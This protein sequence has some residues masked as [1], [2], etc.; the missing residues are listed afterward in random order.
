MPTRRVQS[1]DHALAQVHAGT[2]TVANRK[3]TQFAATQPWA[4]PSRMR[5]C[6]TVNVAATVRFAPGQ[7]F[8]ASKEGRFFGRK[9]GLPRGRCLQQA[10]ARH[11][12][13]NEIR[14][15]LVT[16]GS[17]NQR[18]FESLQQPR[19]VLLARTGA[20]MAAQCTGPRPIGGA[21][22]CSRLAPQKVRNPRLGGR[23]DEVDTV[24]SPDGLPGNEIRPRWTGSH[25]EI[26]SRIAADQITARGRCSRCPRAS[27][28]LLCRS[29]P[30]LFGVGGEHECVGT[31]SLI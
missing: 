30:Q 26:L 20:Q 10:K 16:A 4:D 13:V 12:G 14:P 18:S 11:L 28:S 27:A 29:H 22:A 7:D 25:S 31:R 6:P 1:S 21:P 19:L 3:I 2:L 9:C 8:T 5:P 17:R 15:R 23:P 24:R